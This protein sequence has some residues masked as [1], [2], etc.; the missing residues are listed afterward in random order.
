MTAITLEKR[1]FR[2]EE[3]R[4]FSTAGV[5]YNGSPWL[6]QILNA[7]TFLIPGGERFI[8]RSCKACEP[9]AGPQLREELKA[10]YFQE[11]SHSHAHARVL[12]LMRREGLGMDCFRSAVDW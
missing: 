1:P 7:Y 6:T 3:T 5:W 11:G 4:D 12:D 8:I 2:F 10:L 9:A